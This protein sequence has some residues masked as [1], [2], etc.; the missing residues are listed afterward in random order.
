[1]TRKPEGE[2]IGNN[3]DKQAV[4]DDIGYNADLYIFNQ[5]VVQDYSFRLLMFGWFRLLFLIV[6]LKFLGLKLCR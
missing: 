6:N 1:M 4:L 3:D 5:V 2:E